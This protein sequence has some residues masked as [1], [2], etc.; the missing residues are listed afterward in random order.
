MKNKTLILMG[1]MFFTSVASA[2]LTY[3]VKG[4]QRVSG[5]FGDGVCVSLL[6]NNETKKKYTF[7]LFAIDA[8]GDGLSANPSVMVT[9]KPEFNPNATLVP[10]AKIRGWLCFDEPEYGWVP[11]TIE[12]TVQAGE[13]TLKPS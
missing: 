6:I 1:F 9:K 5:M 8:S 4:V 10:N 3:E 11:E 13:K 7:N 12:F 2:N